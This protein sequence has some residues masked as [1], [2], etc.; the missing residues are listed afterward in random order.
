MTFFEHSSFNLPLAGMH[1]V[2][3]TSIDYS[4]FWSQLQSGSLLSRLPFLAHNNGTWLRF[5]KAGIMLQSFTL[6]LSPFFSLVQWSN[7]LLQCLLVVNRI[8]S[9][10]R[11][12]YS[13][14]WGFFVR[15]FHYHTTT[16]THTHIHSVCV[17]QFNRLKLTKNSCQTSPVTWQHGQVV[18]DI[19]RK[20]GNKFDIKY[21]RNIWRKRHRTCCTRCVWVRVRKMSCFWSD[22]RHFLYLLTDWHEVSASRQW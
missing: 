16:D 20:R 8:Q 13:P 22:E 15:S 5:L 21:L 4:L 6:S 10:M 7:H 2:A 1:L 14:W 12:S 18:T 3:F 11:R 19:I 17:C 9:Q